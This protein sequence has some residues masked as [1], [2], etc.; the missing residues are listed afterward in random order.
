MQGNEPAA[1]FNNKTEGEILRF[2][3]IEGK[4]DHLINEQKDKNTRTKT[5]KDVSLLRPGKVVLRKFK[6]YVLLNSINSW[7][8]QRW[9]WLSPH[10]GRGKDSDS[11]LMKIKGEL[12]SYKLC[13][14]NYSI[15]RF[16]L[17]LFLNPRSSNFFL[18]VF[19]CE[20]ATPFINL[21]FNILIIFVSLFKLK[22]LRQ[23]ISA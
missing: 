9:K 2:S 15:L 12:Y 18:Q 22:S 7:A 3:L 11:V 13:Y 10:R 8:S 20:F 19:I 17:W 4:I 21:I 14:K 16:S 6:K 1:F 5:N 23:Q